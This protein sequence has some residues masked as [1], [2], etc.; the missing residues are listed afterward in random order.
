M[1]TNS[2]GGPRY[3]IVVPVYNEEAVLPILLR[4][5][6]SLMQELDGPADAIFVDDGSSDCS[7]IILRAKAKDVS[8]FDA[9]D[10][11]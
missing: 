1:I 5:L 4:R 11:S 8:R 3:S 9:P 6:D 10:V 2:T 7:S